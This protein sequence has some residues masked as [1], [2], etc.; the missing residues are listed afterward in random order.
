MA[1][2]WGDLNGVLQSLNQLVVYKEHQQHGRSDC[3]GNEL[4]QEEVCLLFYKLLI[5]E[6]CLLLDLEEG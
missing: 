5:M 3:D 1:G 6:A 4:W 2:K